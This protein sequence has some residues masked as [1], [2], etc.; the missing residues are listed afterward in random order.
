[1]QTLVSCS[2]L[3]RGDVDNPLHAISESN[4]HNFGGWRQQQQDFNILQ[5]I[6]I[7]DKRWVGIDA[8]Y[9]LGHT[10]WRYISRMKGYQSIFSDLVKSSMNCS[11]KSK[12]SGR[13]YVYLEKQIWN[14]VNGVFGERYQQSIIS[15]ICLVST[16]LL[17]LYYVESFFTS[18]SS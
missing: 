14:E 18:R 7:E 10:T 15:W 12:T 1:M 9:K 8:V 5:F 13:I 2:I 3:E 6:G 4:E 16:L 17:F 11:I